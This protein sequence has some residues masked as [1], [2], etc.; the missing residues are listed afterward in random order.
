MP[1]GKTNSMR[2]SH[3]LDPL[4]KKQVEEATRRFAS[5]EATLSLADIVR[6]RRAKNSDERAIGQAFIRYEVSEY[7]Q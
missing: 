3:V 4:V 6:A 1:I 7:E 5:G 2:R